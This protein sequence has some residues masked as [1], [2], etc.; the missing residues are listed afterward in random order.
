MNKRAFLKKL[1][2]AISG[3]ALMDALF[4][5]NAFGKNIRPIAD[6]W[7]MELNEFC[8]DLKKGTITTVQWQEKVEELYRRIELNEILK[9][10]DFENLIK[11]FKYPDLGV[12][13]KPVYFP[14]LDGL[15]EKTVFVKKIFGMKK[16]RAIIPHGHS[17]MASAH[18][19]LNG[20]MHLRHYEKVRQ[21]E[22][23]LIIRPTIDRVVLTGDSSSISDEKDNIHWFIANTDT[24]FTFDVI[25]L[26]LNDKPYNI[27]NID[28]YEKEDL[29]DGSIK[30]PVI[31]VQTAL[32]KYGKQ[33]H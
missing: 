13:T 18:L 8:R 15:P 21:E 12:S 17:N 5:Y 3:F 31:D 7:A 10:I 32:K 11:G 6:H 23:D 28:I 20:E 27:H 22:Q 33:H 4:T 16:G 26:D 9:F 1:L 19:I 2:T 25:M 24:A 30:V 14:K 29:S